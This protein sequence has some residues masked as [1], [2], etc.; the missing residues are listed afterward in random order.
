M[1]WHHKTC[2]DWYLGLVGGAGF[3]HCWVTDSIKLERTESLI[4]KQ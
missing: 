2:N 1:N 3:L 4:T